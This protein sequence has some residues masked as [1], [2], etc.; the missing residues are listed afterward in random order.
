M[1]WRAH[2]AAPGPGW[3]PSMRQGFPSLPGIHNPI[4][5]QLPQS[6]LTHAPPGTSNISPFLHTHQALP[7]S[8]TFANA[9][10]SAW[11]TLVTRKKIQLLLEGSAQMSPV[12]QN[13]LYPP[14]P[15]RK[16]PQAPAALAH[17]S[18]T[19]WL[20]WSSLWTGPPW[21]PLPHSGSGMGQ[22]L[23]NSA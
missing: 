8:M 13:H 7:V 18:P 5:C 1:E 10:L 6:N 22:V 9:G 12:L 3:V 4:W 15:A 2:G 17:C 14:G 16:S 23:T 21:A 20:I 11:L 19:Q